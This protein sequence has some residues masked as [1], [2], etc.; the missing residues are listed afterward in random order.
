LHLKTCLNRI[1]FASRTRVVVEK[2]KTLE[3]LPAAA[4]PAGR[5]GGSGRGGGLVAAFLEALLL[6]PGLG[7]RLALPDEPRRRVGGEGR[8]LSGRERVR[9]A[10]TGQ[11]AVGHAQ[12]GGDDVARVGPVPAQVDE[13]LR[14]V[15]L[16]LVELLAGHHA[17]LE[18]PRGGRE[19]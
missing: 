15:V 2:G 6:A 9:D 5:R 4:L 16:E 1:T 19:I 11:A 3:W 18:L 17:L 13:P 8:D 7:V 14:G 12:P 10:A